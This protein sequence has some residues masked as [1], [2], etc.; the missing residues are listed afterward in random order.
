MTQTKREG[1]IG[2]G[3]L[4]VVV[5]V[6]V[7]VVAGGCGWLWL[8]VVV[9]VVVVPDTFMTCVYV[10]ITCAHAKLAVN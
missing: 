5:V 4:V 1:T 2:I 6:V 9:V 8:V 10:H 7:A 3:S